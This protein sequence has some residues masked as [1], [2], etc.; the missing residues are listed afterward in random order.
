MENPKGEKLRQD[1]GLGVLIPKKLCNIF[2]E[3]QD[4]TQCSCTTSLFLTNTLFLPYFP[5]QIFWSLHAQQRSPLIVREML[6]L[7]GQM[8]QPYCPPQTLG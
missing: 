4:F 7:Q 2:E 6:V 1:E 5:T 8:S 3:K